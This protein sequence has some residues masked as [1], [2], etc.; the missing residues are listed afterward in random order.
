VDRIPSLQENKNFLIQQEELKSST[1]SIRR[2][3]L[4]LTFEEYKNCQLKLAF[5]F[6]FFD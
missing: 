3:K 5:L 1:E 4:S 2:S 6:I